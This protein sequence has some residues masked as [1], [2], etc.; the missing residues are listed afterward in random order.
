MVSSFKSENVEI[1]PPP[2]SF[3]KPN[4]GKSF[5]FAF[6][7]K[8]DF[9]LNLTEP[10]IDAPFAA[11]EKLPD[12]VSAFIDLAKQSGVMVPDGLKK[13]SSEKIGGYYRHTYHWTGNGTYKNFVSL[14]SKVYQAN[15]KCAFK[16]ISLIALTGA[17]LKMDC[18]IILTTQQ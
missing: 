14:V 15:A 12:M 9:G 3:I 18:H 13:V 5:K 16:R 8:L 7:C 6:S 17:N 4:D 11:N 1:M 2:Y 10:I